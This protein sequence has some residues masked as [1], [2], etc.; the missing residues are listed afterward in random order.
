MKS[1]K[2]WVALIAALLAV[3]LAAAFLLKGGGGVSAAV[4]QDGELLQ[5]IDLS[6]V[7]KRYTF[8]VE[9]PAGSNTVEVERGR[10]RILRADCLDQIC[11]HQGW[12]SGGAVPIVCLP[13]RLV[14]Q[15]GGGEEGI[16]GVAG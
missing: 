15:I 11:V 9:G 8:T 6:R 12:I 2:F 5:T 7:E 3:C 16:D 13:N 14:I 1:T 10:I 4:Y